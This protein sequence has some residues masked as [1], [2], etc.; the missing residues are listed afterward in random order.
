MLRWA[1]ATEQFGDDESFSML[2]AMDILTSSPH[3]HIPTTNTETHKP[4]D[5]SANKQRSSAMA[6]PKLL[7]FD[8][9]VP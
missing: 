4:N 6:K 7:Y 3:T 8:I 9:K 5:P 2:D 1:T